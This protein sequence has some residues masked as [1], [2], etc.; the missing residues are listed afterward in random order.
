MKHGWLGALA[1]C[2][3]IGGCGGSEVCSEE[4]GV[5]CTVVGTGVAGLTTDGLPGTETELYLPMNT[6]VGQDGLLYILDWNN[7]RIRV[8][9]GDGLVQTVVGTGHIGDAP[10]GPALDTSLNHPTHVVFEA[11]GSM[12]ISAWHNSKVMR[13][14]PNTRTVASICGTGHRSFNGDGLPGTET[15]LDLPSATAIAPDGSILI[16]DQANQRIRRLSRD[17]VVETVAGTGEPGYSGD[18]GAAVEA[19]LA[20]PVSQSAPPAGG[21]ATDA[22]GVLFIADTLNHVV[23][24]VGVD[25]VIETVAGTGAA[26]NGPG[27]DA[28]TSALHTP[29]DVAVD[30]RGN[31]Y[32]AD[33]VNSCVRRVSPDGHMDTVAGVCGERGYAGDNGPAEQALLD[34]PYGVHVAPNDLLYVTD[35][36]NQAIRVIY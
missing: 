17:D 4:P 19:Q 33:T 16:S 8:L 10:D 24:R 11:D 3:V 28:V 21:I 2:L 32:I 18:G 6:A 35:T 9:D 34:R 14:D 27:G 36:H 5:I 31:L 22:A 15:V 1:L 20:L 25:G 29:S 30:S 23:R 7:H 12:I 13:Y 26:G